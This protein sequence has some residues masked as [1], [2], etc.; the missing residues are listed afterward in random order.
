M[1][2]S[3]DRCFFGG[4][5]YMVTFASSAD[6]VSLQL[7]DTGPGV[8]RGFVAIAAK[9]D[10]SSETTLRTFTSDPLPLG[11]LTQFIDEA[12]SRLQS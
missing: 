6:D 11:L 8:G 5:H 12:R 3:E 9:L 2:V 4:R 7:E 10:D 1:D